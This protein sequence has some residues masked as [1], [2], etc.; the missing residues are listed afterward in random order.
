MPKLTEA[1]KALVDQ[2]I[3]DRA[4]EE[5][6]KLLQR[7]N[8]NLFTMTEL[9]GAMGVAKG[10]LYNY[11]ED[12]QAVILYVGER[13]NDELLNKIKNYVAEHPRDFVRCLRYMFHAYVETMQLNQFMDLA[14]VTIQYE[15]L[16][17]GHDNQECCPLYDAVAQK[18]RHFLIEFLAA[19]QQACVFKEYAPEAMATFVS[20]QFWGINA[21]SMV[22]RGDFRTSSHME[23]LVQDAEAILLATLCKEPPVL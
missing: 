3:R 1:K 19:G 18:N 12:K 7:R 11:F 10:T 20:M 17:K 21:Y 2:F 9:A 5:A 16:K 15:L 8:P 6:K 23:Q 14:L 22:Q 13:I 4:Y